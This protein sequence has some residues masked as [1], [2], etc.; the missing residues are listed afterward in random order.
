MTSKNI[1]RSLGGLDPE[2]I[3]KAAPA[4]K[5]QKKNT[6]V[7]WGALA[8]CLCLVIGIAFRV[9]I[10]FIPNQATDIFREGTLV[11]ITSESDLPAQ[12]D[13]KLL[14][15]NLEFPQYEFYYKQ[16]GSD[17]TTGYVGNL[18]SAENTENWYS[19]LAV[20][21]DSEGKILLHCM[22]G[23]TTVDDWK[24]SMVFTKNA[25]ETITVGGIE[26]QIAR[27]DLSLQYEYWYYAI[28]EYDDVV[29]DIRVQSNNAE[30]VYDVLAT[31]INA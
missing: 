7:K 6:W 8:A 22:F 17:D 3:A 4:E 30:Y 27:L 25:T 19:L 12:Y 2:L 28:F 20:K 18:G 15:F 21:H 9:A 23:D 31:L 16:G 10:G 26:V 1:Y 5:A 13:G 24:V 11:E 14:A 29:Y